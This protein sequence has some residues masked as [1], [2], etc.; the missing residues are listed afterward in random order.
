[1]K[2]IPLKV[3]AIIF[4]AIVFAN[5][6]TAQEISPKK[7]SYNFINEYGFIASKNVGFTSVFVNG[8]KIK[9]SDAIGIGIG[10][11]INT[12]SYQ[13][14]PLFLN[15]RHYFNRGR[16]LIP[17]INVAIGTA[18]KFWD[19]DVRER[20]PVFINGNID[21][22]EWQY[23]TNHLYGFGLYSTVAS[24]FSV[25]AFSFSAGL[26]FRTFPREKDFNAGVEV[27]VG[28]SF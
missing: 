23:K 19:E 4:I 28:Y 15:Y 27:K 24:G 22:Y 7:I 26:F 11:G 17:H 21:H 10:Y 2:N 25:K 1:M 12:A 16:K 14:V 6:V 8:I 3:S 18:I 20:V 13:E 5:A 9:N